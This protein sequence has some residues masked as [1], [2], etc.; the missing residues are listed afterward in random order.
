MQ[1]IKNWLNGRFQR[2]VING[3]FSSWAEVKSGV[4]QGSVLGPILFI[5]FIN[6]LGENIINRILKFADDT[7]SYGR[8]DSQ[9]EVQ[10]LQRDLDDLADWATKWGMKYNEKKCKVMHL[11]FNNLKEDYYI[12]G[13]KLETIDSEKDLD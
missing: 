11:G 7:K 3:N 13:K 9:N 6:D 1:W 4:P 2:V 12:N 5:I 8:V 10:G